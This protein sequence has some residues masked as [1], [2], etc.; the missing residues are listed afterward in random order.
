MWDFRAY[1]L[2]VLLLMSLSRTK[3]TWTDRLFALFFL[4]AA[5]TH[6]RY[7]GIATVFLC[8]W[9]ARTIRTFLP[10]RLNADP[11]K[12]A[13]EQLSTSVVS[14]PVATIALAA[15]LALLA[16]P[17]FPRSRAIMETFLPLPAD[18]HP[19]KAVQYLNHHRPP[20][21]MFNR[22]GW[23]GYLIYAMDPP[24]KVF[25][26]GRAD[27]YGE[28]IFGDYEK[29]A[30]L[31][32]DTESLLEHYD[33]DWILFPGDSVLVRY[34]KATGKWGVTYSD[35]TASVLVRLAGKSP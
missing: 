33:I 7:I 20:G 25:I 9:L 23:G 26:D 6:Q 1:L 27:M 24:Q 18:V 8:P 14:G 35:E 16:T 19:I 22:Y 11:S 10:R 31:H 17:A 15:V 21:K 3:I 4:N 29:I 30:A 28:E 12:G 13:A 2:G 32:K 34:L 5:M